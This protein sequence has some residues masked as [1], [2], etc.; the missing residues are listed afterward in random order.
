MDRLGKSLPPLS[1]LLPFEAAARLGSFTKAAHELNLT[2][3]AVS[4]QVRAI[5]D[6]LGTRLFERRNRAIFLT[7]AGRDLGQVVTGAL[8]DIAARAGDMRRARQGG[9]DVVL[10]SQLCEAFYWLMPRLSGFHQRH[11]RIELRIAASTRPLAE[12][13][14][15]FDV[16]LQTSGRPSGPHPAVLTASDEIFPVCCPG[17]LDGRPLPLA[18]SDL[19]DH[20]LLHHKADPPDWLGW[21]GWLGRHGLASRVGDRGTVFDSYPV[22]LQAAVQ[23]HGIALGWRRTTEVLLRTGAL[24]RPFGEGASVPDEL[25]VYRRRGRARPEADALLAWLKG[26]LTA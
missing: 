26:E 18:L 22:M 8:G 17:Y 11:P 13:G 2:Q 10:F 24:V 1:S 6:D 9:G 20:H 21:D 5:E 19:P 4:R 14:D 7:E 16:A 12:A 3:A 23:G 15:D 25:S